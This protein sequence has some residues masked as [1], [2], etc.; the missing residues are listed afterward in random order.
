MPPPTSCPHCGGP[1]KPGLVNCI[2][3]NQALSAELA[4]TAV[5]CPRCRAL[6]VWGGTRCVR[7]NGW[8]V[9][10][11]VFCNSLSPHTQQACLSCREPFAGAPQRKAEREAERQRQ[12]TLQT[13][14][15]V[16]QVAAPFLG[17]VAGGLLGSVFG[18]GSQHCQHQYGHPTPD[19]YRQDYVGRTFGDGVPSIPF[20]GHEHHHNSWNNDGLAAT[21]NTWT[22]QGESATNSWGTSSSGNASSDNSWFGSSSSGDEN[23]TSADTGDTSSCFDSG[24]SDSGSNDDNS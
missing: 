12:Q 15:A 13:V 10:Q 20:G 22:N 7:C 21:D 19:A 18:S 8:V 5:P 6:N 3:C 16:G 24:S 1:A 9:V 4:A 23:Y 17:A 11:C 2:Y 14:G